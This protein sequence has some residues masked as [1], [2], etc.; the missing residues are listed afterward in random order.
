[1]NSAA[2]NSG[3][4]S[5]RMTNPVIRKLGKVQERAEGG[6]KAAS[7]A[8]IAKKTAFF[9]L[10]T[11]VGVAAF[12]VVK[13]K[14]PYT[15][16]NDMGPIMLLAVLGTGLLT[17]I[18]PMLAWLIRPTIPVTG[19]L[20]CL[21]QGFILSFVCD[22]T[23]A[24]YTK[25]AWMALLITIV[26]VAVMLFLYCKRI[27]RITKK[28]N[29][30]LKTLF[31]TSIFSSIGIAVLGFI[32]ATAGLA[33]YIMGNPAISIVSGVVFVIIAA[34]FLLSDFDAIEVTVEKSLPKK[35]EWAAAYGLVFTVIWLY[36]KVLSLLSSASNKD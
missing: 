4:A 9:L 33:Q 24:Q 16:I 3:F 29:A 1:M 5:Y 10:M 21:S 36:L 2:Q 28:F 32:P 20:Y 35:Y 22:Y 30:V 7:Y 27:I 19:T 12:F 26:I 31:F 17:L 15:N 11:I 8:G 13:G 18:T 34:L 25:L 23:G 14:Y 6:A